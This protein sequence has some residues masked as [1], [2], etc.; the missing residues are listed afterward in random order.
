MTASGAGESAVVVSRIS[1]LA[2]H[3]Q[4]VGSGGGM[5]RETANPACPR[6]ASSRMRKGPTN[7]EAPLTSVVTRSASAHD[8]LEDRAVT[9]Q[10]DVLGEVLPKV[11]LSAAA[12]LAPL[13]LRCPCQA[14]DRIRER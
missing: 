8:L 5:R 12:H 7:P 3:D 1:F 6:C 13:L 2:H 10:N 14:A 9:R 4:E 11:S